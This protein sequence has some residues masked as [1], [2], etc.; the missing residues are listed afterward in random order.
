MFS[1][2]E[3]KRGNRRTHVLDQ[4]VARQTDRVV[5][6]GR[7]LAVVVYPSVRSSAVWEGDAVFQV[8]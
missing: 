1:P 8:E 2:G 3:H 6:D 4:P 7:D 5:G